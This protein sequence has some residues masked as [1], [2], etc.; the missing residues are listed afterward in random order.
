MISV[1]LGALFIAGL[2]T[3]GTRSIV[4]TASSA[5]AATAG[6]WAALEK[7][8]G[9]RWAQRFAD[10]RTE[11]HKKRHREAGG[12]DADFRPG[13]R[14]YAAD[15]YHAFWERRLEAAKAR[16][17]A[18]GPYV[19]RGPLVKRAASRI[20]GALVPAGALA[21]RLKDK[22]TDL[23]AQRAARQAEQDAAAVPA[24][25]DDGIPRRDPAELEAEDQASALLAALVPADLTMPSENREQVHALLYGLIRC[26]E[27]DG[28]RQRYDALTDTERRQFWADLAAM[29]PHDLAAEVG[30][31]LAAAEEAARQRRARVEQLDRDIK[32]EDELESASANG[33]PPPGTDETTDT[34]KESSMTAPTDAAPGT[35]EVTTNA[36][37]R[38]LF[39]A[40]STDAR[41]L[42]DF[43]AQMEKDQQTIAEAADRV[44]TICAAVDFDKGAVT[45]V[46]HIVDRV[47][48]LQLGPWAEIIDEV[49]EA[50]DGGRT[51][52]EKYR[53]AEA[54]V[55]AAGVDGATLNPSAA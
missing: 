27:L 43:V 21:G 55:A 1:A 47:E 8:Q 31:E 18:R 26:G 6:D 52:L 24:D 7:I 42:L 30:A 32:A 5:K 14:E 22:V 45:A 12:T 37:L 10:A 38:R 35:E 49:V 54:D 20:A 50:A 28:W 40:N 15:L 53:D 34:S 46:V 23:R 36:G 9:R 4:D 33:T 17:D 11:R 51:A 3:M 19:Y 41:K 29:G 25:V 48:Q 39:E 16:R 13:G 2:I 44:G